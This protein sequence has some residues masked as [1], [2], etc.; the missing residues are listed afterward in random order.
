MPGN[1]AAILPA[2]PTGMA[3]PQ[4]V[5]LTCILLEMPKQF[6][7]AEVGSENILTVGESD[8]A[9][10]HVA[11]SVQN[12]KGLRDGRTAPIRQND[13]QVGYSV[14]RRRIQPTKPVPSVPSRIAPGAGIVGVVS[15][16]T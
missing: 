4:W 15:P 11:R 13:C 12:T 5:V 3:Q 8:A 2:G 10:R 16:C 9:V 1:L 14:L 7:G 6:R